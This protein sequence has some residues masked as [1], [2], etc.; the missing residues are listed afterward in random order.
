MLI[1]Q[2]NVNVRP[3]SAVRT[4]SVT[5]KEGVLPSQFSV[6][7]DGLTAGTGLKFFCGIGELF[8]LHL[9]VMNFHYIGEEKI[10]FLRIY[11]L[12]K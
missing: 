11:I 4:S 1:I 7:E 10:I 2:K 12:K 8:T 6:T 9:I 5:D 3:V